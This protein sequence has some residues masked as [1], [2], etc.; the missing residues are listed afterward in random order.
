MNLIERIRN[1]RAPIRSAV[2]KLITKIQN[3]IENNSDDVVSGAQNLDTARQ[4]QCQL[5]NILETCGMKLH[6]W[7]SNSKE[8]LNSSTDQEHS[9]ST[10]AELAIKTLGVSWKPT[11]DH[12]MFKVSISSMASYRKRDVLSVIAR[13]YDPLGLIGPVISKAKI[14]LQIMT[15]KIELGRILTRCNRTRVEQLCVISKSPGGAQNRSIHSYRFLRKIHAFRIRRCFGINLRS[16]SVHALSLQVHLAKVILHTDSTIAIAWIN[17]PANQ[18]KTSVGNRVSKLQTLTENFEWKHIP[19]AQ[20]PA[21]IIS[22]G[23]NPE[24][25]SSLTLWWNGPQH[26]DIHE[27]FSELSLSSSDEFKMSELKKQSDISLTSILDS[28]FENDLLNITNNYMKLIR[29]FSYIFRF[30]HNVKNT[31]CH[32]GPLTNEELQNAKHYLIKRIQVTVFNKE[33]EILRNRGIIKKGIDFTGQF[34]I[35]DKGQR[36]GIYHKCY[37]TIFICFITKAIHIE[38]VTE[39]T[40]EAMIATLKQFFSRRGKSTSVCTD[41]VTNFIG[42]NRESQRL[43]NLIKNPPDILA[44]YLTN[45]EITSKFIPA[46]SP[47]FGGLWEAGVK[48]FKRHF[49]RT[50]GDARLTLEQFITITT[51]IESIL[52]S[53]PLT[54]MSSDPNDFAVLSPGHF[55]IGLFKVYLSQT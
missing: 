13:L 22:R 5:Q 52:N 31:S 10:N 33:I 11:G 43:Y 55:L 2:T 20:K 32:S 51:Q 21:D 34:Y 50:V 9:F 53:R 7:N 18:L 30:L 8:L 17:T 36:K 1:K 35:E 39:L 46:R 26:L 24:E 29:I 40:T 15:W 4:L 41:N 3:Y 27:Q 14:F 6:K 38:V 49:K 25:L 16:H 54:P 48:S 28:N 19:S 12:F 44:N 45:E 37:A 23:V 47:N 42:A